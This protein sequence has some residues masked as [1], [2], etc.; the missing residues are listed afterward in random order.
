MLFIPFIENAFKH[1]ANKKKENA[2]SIGLSIEKPLIRFHCNNFMEENP[3]AAAEAGGLGN[4]LIKKRLDL[5]YP[6]RHALLIKK[7]NGQYM[8][9]LTIHTSIPVK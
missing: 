5:L 1:S 3:L 2:I 4:E 9:E 7:E 6:G 8:V